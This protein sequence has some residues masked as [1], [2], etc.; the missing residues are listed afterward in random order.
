MIIDPM[1]T[2][3]I[4]IRDRVTQ[5]AKALEQGIRF[6]VE[7]MQRPATRRSWLAAQAAG[8]NLMFRAAPVFRLLTGNATQG[9]FTMNARIQRLEALWEERVGKAG[10]SR[11]GS[12][13]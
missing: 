4:Q 2:E 3:M 6:R 1:I 12:K 8:E 5:L 11:W 9:E 13:S 10:A 7:L